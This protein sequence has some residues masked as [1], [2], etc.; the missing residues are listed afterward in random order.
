[1]PV[2]MR[3]ED[4]VPDDNDQR[5]LWRLITSATVGAAMKA[6]AGIVAYKARP[7]SAVHHGHAHGHTHKTLEYIYI[8]GGRGTVQEEGKSFEVK[9]G[10]AFV[11]RGETPHAVWSATEEPLMAFCV[12]VPD[13]HP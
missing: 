5:R 4:V 13:D 1:M 9:S 7:S 6:T 3:R 12:T 10:D 8:L 11:I 2:I